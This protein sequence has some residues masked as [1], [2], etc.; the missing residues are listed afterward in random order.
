M[1]V[2]QG[3]PFAEYRAIDAASNS[4][5]TL[6]KR[7]PRYLREMI[8][9][10][11]ADTKEQIIGRAFHS[12]VLEPQLFYAEYAHAGQCAAVTS[13][14]M[15]CMNVGRV[16]RVGEWFCGVRGHDPEPDGEGESFTCLDGEQWEAVHRMRE[17]V[18]S[19]PLA[20]GL[21]E[22]AQDRELSVL[23]TDERTGQACKARWDIPDADTQLIADLKSCDDASPASF[24]RS[25]GKWGYHR[26]HAFYMSGAEQVSPGAFN[27]FV[28][29]ACE[30]KRPYDVALYRLPEDAVRVGAEEVRGLLARYAECMAAQEFPGYRDDVMTLDVPAWVY[31]EMME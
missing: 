7:S 20:G 15:R 30:K 31:A 18:L 19:H 22:R 12:L 6:V 1:R 24:R 13:K 10:P 29:I 28:F 23:W 14:G 4:R 26:Q 5:L 11:P 16:R 9:N 27:A 2:L 17:A 3:L 25:I 21:I 8:E